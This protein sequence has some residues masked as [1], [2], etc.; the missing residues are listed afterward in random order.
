MKSCQMTLLKTVCFLIE[1]SN[2]ESASTYVYKCFEKI[3]VMLDEKEADHH[4]K[5]EIC[6]FMQMIGRRLIEHKESFIGLNTEFIIKRLQGLTTDRI[7]KVQLAAREALKEWKELEKQFD[8]VEKMKM[9]VK[10]DM[11][12]PDQ[13]IEMN[14]KQSSNPARIRQMDQD[15]SYDQGQ[16]S[17]PYSRPPINTQARPQSPNRGPSRE[18]EYRKNTNPYQDRAPR[19][20]SLEART[21]SSKQNSIARGA[22]VF[23]S[24]NL[25]EKT[26]LKQRA[27]NFQKKRTGTGG[28][29]IQQYDKKDGTRKKTSFNDLR[30]KFKKQVMHDRMNYGRDNIQSKQKY[31]N[32][33]DAGQDDADEDI[34]D[35][36][37]QNWHQKDQPN[38]EYQ[39]PVQSNTN[40]VVPATAQK[41]PKNNKAP[42]EPYFQQDVVEPTQA[43]I[44]QQ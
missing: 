6:K 44:P 43:A 34:E 39:H 15:N 5:T 10:F 1:H 26:F 9:R 31:Q 42:I 20:D 29:F 33:Y 32:Y 36:E 14:L 8:E 21:E 30:D 22:E 11:K 7:S 38:Q 37:N 12:D 35:E 2:F 19:E 40:P 23:K 24:N 28:G 13:L 16:Q 41:M 27:H 4:E 17:Q 18:A 25:V 3:V